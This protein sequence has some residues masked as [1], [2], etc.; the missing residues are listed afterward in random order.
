M[1]VSPR[2]LGYDSCSHFTVVDSQGSISLARNPEHHA[3]TKHIDVQY[4]FI[5]QHLA[6]KN[7]LTAVRQHIR[8]ARRRI[9]QTTGSREV[10][11]DDE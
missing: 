3:R 5:R 2:G 4:H 9:D 8:D 1:A 6:E 10:R 11:V 7:D